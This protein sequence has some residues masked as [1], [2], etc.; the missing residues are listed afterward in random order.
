MRKI[1][2]TLEAWCIAAA[3][4]LPGG[5]SLA[6]QEK[7]T[8]RKTGDE[9][10]VRSEFSPTHDLVIR[11]WRIANEGAYLIPKD[12]PLKDY[13]K[14]LLVHLNN[15]EYPATAFQTWGFLSGNHGS[16]YG[17][18]LVIPDHQMTTAD[19]GGKITEEDGYPYIIMQIT[20]K[21]KILV[22]PWGSGSDYAHRLRH[23]RKAPL[24]YKGKP[25]P[26]QKSILA[27]LRPL[28][29][30]TDYRLLADGKTP[31]PEDTDV[32]CDFVDLIFVHDVISPNAAVRSVM[33]NPGKKPSPEWVGSWN[34]MMVN[35]PEL[36][37]QYPEYMKLAAM[38]T[39]SNLYR[40][41][42]RGANVLYRKAV[43]HSKLK[44]VSS[45]DVMYGWF[46][47]ITRK[48]KQYFYIPKM[49]PLQLKGRTKDDPVLDCDFSANYLMPEKMNLHVIFT[50][51][52][53]LDPEDLPDRF[54]R[55]A[56]DNEPELGI[57]LGYSLI[58]GCT[59]RKNKSAE[60]DQFYH[61]WYTKKM[62][63]YVYSLREIE[64][65]K[66]M[67]TVCYK[68]YFNPKLEP[69]A[70]SF[71]WHREGKSW[72]V[73]LDFHKELKDKLIRLPAFFA[74]KKITVV[75]KTPSLTLHTEKTIPAEGI[76]L[77]VSGKHGYIVLKLD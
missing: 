53:A 16:V 2:F 6:A 58:N 27:Q 7:I 21:D 11:N 65:G 32:V 61:F 50:K 52:D 75:E 59:A 46:G 40:F 17:R 22:H 3:I 68:Q 5:L 19:I 41:E 37:K 34:M 48:K 60:R 70:T 47:E 42:A 29:R 54:I 49:K 67:E 24:F 73:Y 56:G 25:L 45:L 44:G 72:L 31:V 55:T 77:D 36:Q 51:K 33:E 38:A 66:T 76:R 62:Y 23:H 64:P 10:V 71:Y 26:Y 18:T 35:T 9:F 74:G 39:Y 13:R 15:D 12:V 20:D 69:D 43:Y 28:N 57:A 1:F 8:V 30:I 4:L 14:G 63:P